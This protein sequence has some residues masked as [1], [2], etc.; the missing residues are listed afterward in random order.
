S[1]PPW[2]LRS[3]CAFDVL[4]R[5][6]PQQVLTPAARRDPPRP[7]APAPDPTKRCAQLSPHDRTP[8]KAR[9][10]GAWRPA[11]ARRAARALR[12]PS[13]RPTLSPHFMPTEEL[14]SQRGVKFR[15]TGSPRPFRIEPGVR[16]DDFG[17]RGKVGIVAV[18]RERAVKQRGESFAGRQR[19]AHRLCLL[20]REA[21]ILQAKLSGKAE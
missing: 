9:A 16:L 3:K 21:G 18:E 13:S 8:D 4:A 5:K 7:A 12:C 17:H 10:A 20:Q 2:P 6:P 14:P 19:H 11:N 15:L 1:L